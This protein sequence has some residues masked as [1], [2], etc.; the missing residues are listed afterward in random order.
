MHA[1]IMSQETKERSDT[2][3][4]YKYALAAFLAAIIF[5]IFYKYSLN[6]LRMEGLTDLKEHTLHAQNIYMNRLKEAWLKRPYLLWHL[7][8]KC[9]IKFL[10]MP[11][12]E[13]AA[14]C[15][16]GFA[17]L[18]Y[19]LTFYML[20]CTTS[21]VSGCD[22]G[23]VSACAAGALGLVQPMYV[24]WFNNYQYEGQFSINPIFNPTHM[25]VKPI[26]L[27]CFMLGV[28]LIR[29]YIGEDRLYFSNRFRSKWLFVFFS[30]ALFLSTFT[31]PT[32]MYISRL[33]AKDTNAS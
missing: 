25:A 15:C 27:L 2:K 8:A 31:K 9:C 28:D 3:N 7:C 33:S 12:E 24:Y 30:A 17:V 5:V 26:G 22:T 13:A 23:M 16:A 1:K 11:V 20:N 10:A 32:F 19:F 29:S 14:F 6:Q 18:T 21:K 4:Y